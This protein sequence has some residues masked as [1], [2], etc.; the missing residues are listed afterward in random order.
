MAMPK[1]T[2]EE[3]AKHQM[4]ERLESMTEGLTRVCAC[5]EALMAGHDRESF[6]HKF[7]CYLEAEP[8][9]F[10]LDDRDPEPLNVQL[11]ENLRDLAARILDL[12]NSLERASLVL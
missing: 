5:P 11:A 8:T 10:W 7:Y 6:G 4:A 12:V 3:V 9:E 1:L 2:T